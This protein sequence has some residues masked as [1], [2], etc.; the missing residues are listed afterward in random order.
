MA[1]LQ[2]LNS[3]FSQSSLP[4]TDKL[5]S[6]RTANYTQI[7]SWVS[8]KSSTLSLKTP[9][10]QHGKLENVHLVS[11]SRQDKLKE[12]HEFLFEMDRC[13]VPVAPQSYKHLLEACSNLRS[14][15]FGKL[16]HQRLGKDPPAFLVNSVLHM[17]CDCGSFDDARKVFDEM[18]QRTL[19]SWVIII[20]A[21]AHGGLLEDALELFLRIQDSDLKA[22]P[23]IILAF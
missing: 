11:L 10:M 4:H 1:G 2:L 22:N 19:V 7:P 23:S 12:A 9:D 17:Y 6:I 8:L 20:S 15:D 13:N 18:G 14:L 21:Y 3:A 16:I 5:S